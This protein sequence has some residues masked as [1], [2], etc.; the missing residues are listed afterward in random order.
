MCAAAKGFG[1]LH[2]NQE[3]SAIGFV[4]MR[5]HATCKLDLH[6]LHTMTTTLAAPGYS[7]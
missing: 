4:D 3:L 5:A 2:G 7:T 1:C 6:R